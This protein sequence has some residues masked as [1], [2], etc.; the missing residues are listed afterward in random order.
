[1]KYLV[2][3]LLPPVGMLLAGRAMLALLC[4]LLM[5]TLIGWQASTPRRRPWPVEGPPRKMTF[6]PA[7]RARRCDVLHIA[8][9]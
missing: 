1:M 3:I 9:S 4:L 5:I 7:M 6:L 8:P 2:A